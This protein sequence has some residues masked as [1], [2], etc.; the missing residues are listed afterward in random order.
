[1]G[2]METVEIKIMTEQLYENV[3][4]A[5]L[6]YRALRRY[7]DR[8]AFIDGDR[9]FSYRES[10]QSVQIFRNLLV[11]N[12]VEKGVPI[13]LVGGNHPE[14][15]F[16][17]A[18]ALM[19]GA[20]V[21]SLHPENGIEDHTYALE[22]LTTQ[23]VIYESPRFDT[24]ISELQERCPGVQFIQ[25][26]QINPDQLHTDT[27]LELLP[28]VAI[29]ADDIVG[30]SLSGGTTGKPKGIMHSDRTLA[31]NAAFSCI[32]WD[33]PEQIRFL[34]AT[35]LSHASGAMAIPIL[36]QG[37][38]LIMLDKF[39]P[40]RFREVVK[41]YDANSTFVVPTMMH[42]L[43]DIPDDESPF[44]D[45]QTVIYG[46]SKIDPSM[47]KRMVEKFGQ[48]FV[49]LYGQSEAPN[50]IAALKKDDH[51]PADPEKMSSC[52]RPVGCADVALLD[53]HDQEVPVGEVGEICVRGP[54]V[55][56]GYW[57]KPELTAE[58]FSAGWLHT[59]DLARANAQGYLTIVGRKK[60]MIITGGLNVYP[61]EVE[62]VLGEVPGVTAAA[63]IGIPDEE[64]GERVV[65][66]VTLEDELA[67]TFDDEQ[68]KAFVKER[69][70]SV[71]TPKAVF[72]IDEFP[73]TKIGK[74]DKVALRDIAVARDA[75]H[76]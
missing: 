34:A 75:A 71:Q 8:V 35:P 12:G 59:G 49:Q 3:S 46:A 28:P 58:T 32:E 26:P 7:T 64:W 22:Y 21:T 23:V 24:V 14:T 31:T 30:I 67:Q 66:F 19:E 54:I 20:R 70:G 37:G 55:M 73:L 40:E 39:S 44:H 29:R 13:A 5:T 6:A 57:Q 15:F 56:A 52:G 60:D 42:R 10:A 63:V 51:D 9:E 41:Q 61:A 16:T 48:K 43:L 45:L 11:E 69:K 62:S 25:M 27:A 17:R 68:L 74:P 65:A 2:Q 33:W 72:M 38:A 18:A 76:A 36:M 50:L 47:L 53:E 1:M 4:Y